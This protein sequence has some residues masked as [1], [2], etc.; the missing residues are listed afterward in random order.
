MN[1]NVLDGPEFTRST[2]SHQPDDDR[3]LYFADV[4]KEEMKVILDLDLPERDASIANPDSDQGKAQERKYEKLLFA[5][6]DASGTDLT[7][8]CLSGGGIRSAS[9]ALG[10][11]Q[12]LAR[13]GLLGQFHYLSS[14]SGGGYIASWLSLWR[15]LS[16]DTIVFESLDAAMHTGD[17][18]AQITGIRADS[19]YL[20]PQLGLLSADT[21][22]VFALYL[23]NLLLNWLLFAPFFMGCLMVPRLCVML[24][25]STGEIGWNESAF[26]AACL[27]GGIL[28][29]VALSFAVY[30]RFRKQGD[31]LTDKRFIVTVLY[32]LAA[33]GATFT[34][35]A[36]LAGEFHYAPFAGQPARDHLLWGLAAGALIYF[37]AWFIGRMSS[38]S[39]AS[40]VD[41]PIEKKDVAFWTL[42][43]GVVG[44][45]VSIGMAQIVS[46]MSGGVA[47]PD[48]VG[49]VAAVEV[50]GLSG[51][52]VAY[53]A[54]E[55]LYVGLA[56][57]S[58][59]GDMDREWLARSSGWL[60]AAAIS[61]TVI[62]AI[63]VFAPL[64][65]H[66]D[67][68]HKAQI[69]WLKLNTLLGAGGVSGFVTL[70][71]GWSNKTSATQG[72]RSAKGAPLMRIAGIAAVIFAVSIAALLALFDER[73]ELA[74]KGALQIWRPLVIDGAL[75]ISL[76]GIAFLLSTV[77]NVNRF[78]LHALYRNRLV[79]AFLGS[80]RAGLRTPD[81]F[82]GF[83]AADNQRLAEMRPQSNQNR[84][85]HVINAALNIVASKN[86]A[87]Q[88]RKAESF[89][90]TRLSCGN[91]YVRYRRTKYYGHPKKGISL[92]TAVAISGAAV[93]PNQGYNSSRLIGFLLM[94][95]NV[96]LGWW[97]GNP[98]M[99]SYALAGPTFS[100]TPALRELAGDTTDDS[101]WIYLSDGGHFEN[102][103]LYEMIRRRCR[104][105]VVSDAGCDP[106]CSFEDLGN[107]VRKIYIDFGVSI[108]FEKLEIKARQNP[109]VPGIRF[110]IGSIK[111]PGSSREGWLLYLKPTYQ[112][113]T[114][115]ADIRSYASSSPEFPHE[116]T[117]D[118][119]F[120]ES[121]LESYR[122]LGASIAEYICNGGARMK[123][124]AR[125]DAMSLDALAEVAT[126]L[127]ETE[128]T[129]LQAND[130]CKFSSSG[131]SAPPP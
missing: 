46:G 10:V 27:L 72:T 19:N 84:L 47:T 109:P 18:A 62:S 32:P 67:I 121:Q 81:P 95:F 89:A 30:G 75:L 111:Y 33:S 112:A 124:G 91:P 45:I 48:A 87:W 64:L 21:W 71:L 131:N 129:K 123:P 13:F 117:T 3:T 66:A 49:P 20:T 120:S 44:L 8:L 126:S 1:T 17:E 96:R 65:L 68:P 76:I 102:L 60:S 98:K 85:F 94:L 90:M 50:L 125:P 29:A 104:R 37:F 4:L 128:L 34:F 55:L 7:A 16:P 86:E 99:G 24:L 100:L 114:E 105:I 11:M 38:R 69:E 52:V 88:E 56:S 14:V 5:A 127:L 57:F 51:F 108:D 74:V 73:L 58:H 39:R 116:S 53:L 22:T 43:G 80:A 63:A 83:D 15:R 77:V 36:V 97:L 6:V 79:R 82:T 107:A 70:I 93:S 101:E 113:T 59:K 61:W 42:S 115:R 119:W 41:R 26:R 12:T 31:W 110:A 2:Q 106:T 40:P 78:S 23:R 28:V 122:A 130:C 35:A 103:G 54:G 92:G 9:F 25:A 118:Q